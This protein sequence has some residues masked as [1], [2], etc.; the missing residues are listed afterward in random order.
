[1]NQSSGDFWTA[2][3]FEGE[4]GTGSPSG[5]TG[6][7]LLSGSSPHQSRGCAP[8]TGTG[9]AASMA[10]TAA[11]SAA[12][13][14]RVE[15]CWA[16]CR[17]SAAKART[18]RGRRTSVAGRG[19]SGSS[20]GSTRSRNWDGWA[21]SDCTAVQIN[22]RSAREIAVEKLRNSS[23]R[24]SRS[25]LTASIRRASSTPRS[26]T[27]TNSVLPSSS[28]RS[29]VFG[30]TPS[31]TPATMTSGQPRPAAEAG[32][33]SSTA[34]RI[35]A[36]GARLSIGSS[37][38]NR[39][40]KNCRGLEPGSWSTYRS[41][42]WNSAIMASR[43]RSA[44][45]PTGPPCRACAAQ[46]SESPVADH[47]AHSTV[48]ALAPGSAAASRPAL[49][50]RAILL[51]EP[52]SLPSVPRKAWSPR[53]STSRESLDR[54]PPPSSSS[55]RSAWRRRRRSIAV[56]PPILEVRRATAASGVSSSGSSATANASSSGRTAASSRTAL[57]ATGT[58]TAMSWPVR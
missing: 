2:S 58:L 23:Y 28:P 38:F 21:S 12:S 39:Y 52:P 8:G 42:V 5:T 32:V 27:S 4:T 34:S 40:S 6:A 15:A 29:L 50:I 44:R 54:P 20:Q 43:S 17:S 24:I 55:R 14:G 57:S 48:S 30:H 10:R 35:W 49:S 25:L 51:A 22:R 13:S 26:K 56:A 53:A 31:W 33:S 36:R 47:S 41:A 9:L 46:R 37:W 7:V 18:V 45:T 1:M 3:T 11:A 19:V 16:A